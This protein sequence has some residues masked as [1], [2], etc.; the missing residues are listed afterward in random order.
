M[1]DEVDNSQATV[2]ATTKVVNFKQITTDR[3]NLIDTNSL[4]SLPQR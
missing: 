3:F 2:V 4:L 1:L